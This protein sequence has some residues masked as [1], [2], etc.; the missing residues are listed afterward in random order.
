MRIRLLCTILSV[1]MLLSAAAVPADTSSPVKISAPELEIGAGGTTVTFTV[2]LSDLPPSG[3]ASCRFNTRV[4]GA[5]FTDV[6]PGGQFGGFIG[7]GPT[8]GSDTNG[9]DF[10]WVNTRSPIKGDT[11][12]VTYT[13]ELLEGVGGGDV[14]P[15][16]ITV[17]DD[18]D[19]FL[20]AGGTGVGAVGTDGSLTLLCDHSLTYIGVV[21]PSCES[22]GQNAHWRCSICRKFFADRE[23]A[24]A[25]TA[26][27]VR[28]PATGHTW[29]SWVV[30]REPTCS[31]PGLRARVCL[32]DPAHVETVSLP[33]AGHTLSYMEA[34]A[35]TEDADGRIAHWRCDICGRCFRD[36]GAS[37][38]LEEQ[39]IVVRLVRPG[40]ANGDGRVNAKDITAVMKAILGQKPAQYYEAAADV[41]GDGRVNA[42]DITAIMKMILK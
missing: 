3:L 42:L 35:P 16:V 31:A 4:E 32:N 26:G 21:P 41:T 29:Q 5:V 36:A 1:L 38:D 27:E 9:V 34:I 14:L 19:D 17:S 8:D 22:P 23:G 40:D 13:V 7:I 10:F 39:D 37:Y 24:V 28:V 33:V 15:I 20:D 30:T 12:A 11:V 2:T 25:L 18:P 6:V